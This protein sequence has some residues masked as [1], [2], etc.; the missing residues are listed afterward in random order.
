[1]HK[2]YK[3]L[4]F[5]LL[6]TGALCLLSLYF[7]IQAINKGDISFITVLPLLI[8]SPL[9]I[10]SWMYRLT[11]EEHKII[12]KRLKGTTS[13]TFDEI[14]SIRFHFGTCNLITKDGKIFTISH[15]MEKY[16]EVT[17]F[18]EDKIKLKK[19]SIP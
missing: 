19:G 12:Q 18:I 15:S 5:V 14:E 1:M 3:R 7:I 2:T 16:I 13:V 17:Q 9:F 11:I 4:P 6:F 8:F 10:D